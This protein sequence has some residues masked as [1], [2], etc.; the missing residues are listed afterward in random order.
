MDPCKESLPGVINNAMLEKCVRKQFPSG[1]AGRLAREEGIPLD[2]VEC[3]RLE[4]L[5]NYTRLN[6]HSELLP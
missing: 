5:S 4:Y 6:T 2:E 1:E 3:L